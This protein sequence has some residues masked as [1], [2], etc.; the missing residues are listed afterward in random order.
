MITDARFRN[1]AED[2]DVPNAVGDGWSDDE[3]EK[4]AWSNEANIEELVSDVSSLRM[5]NVDLRRQQTRQNERISDLIENLNQLR[6]REGPVR[7]FGPT[8]QKSSSHKHK[9]PKQKKD[10][11]LTAKER[12]LVEAVEALCGGAVKLPKYR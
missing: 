12:S 10:R 2:D 4:K 9:P 1:V 11:P 6:H 3:T 7:V 8:Y 5:E